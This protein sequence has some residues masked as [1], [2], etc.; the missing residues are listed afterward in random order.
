MMPTPDDLLTLP[1]N[2]PVPID[3]GA[4]AHL[5]G[6]T[7]PDIALPA[8]TGGRIDLADLAVGLAVVFCYPRAGNPG[9]DH[10]GWDEIPGARGCTPQA[11]AFRDLHDELRAVGARVVGLSAQPAEEQAHFARLRSITYPLLSDPELRLAS[12]LELPTFE[13]EGLRLYKR[14]TLILAQRQI[15][16][17]FYPVFPPDRDAAEVLAWIECASGS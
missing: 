9:V 5:P 13:F 10:P 11:C 17:V 16:K 2:L 8:T 1:S 14:V 12:A 3:D 15:A 7:I 6:L 4:C